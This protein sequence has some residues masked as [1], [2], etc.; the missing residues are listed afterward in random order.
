MNF[1]KKL[2]IKWI[3]EDWENQRLTNSRGIG[4]KASLVDDDL[5]SKNTASFKFHTA[6]GGTV[7]QV[8]WYDSTR[9]RYESEI[10]IIGE[11]KDMGQEVSSI[12]M[13]HHLRNG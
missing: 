13:Q 8:T 10:Y 3:R 12:I 11:D 7:A 4:V 1:L 2:V 6:H 5:S 9:D